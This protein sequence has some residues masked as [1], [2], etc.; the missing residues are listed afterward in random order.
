MKTFE[1]WTRKELEALPKRGWNQDIG[2]FER[3]IILPTKRLHDSGFRQMDLVAVKDNIPF[4]R[5]SGCSDVIHIDGIGGF[6]IQEKMFSLGG[7]CIDCL[8]VS[9]L[10]CLFNDN[11]IKV[12]PT[13]SSFEV[14]KSK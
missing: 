7:W 3:L 6:S 12:G 11:S 4:I 8:R 10:L 13:L 9:G 5:L 2:K 14:F 1:N